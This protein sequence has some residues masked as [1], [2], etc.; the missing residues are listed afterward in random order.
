MLPT[1]VTRRSA[2]ENVHGVIHLLTI[3]ATALGQ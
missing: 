1:K 2:I 3:R